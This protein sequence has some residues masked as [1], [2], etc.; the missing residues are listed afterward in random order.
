MK[1]TAYTLQPETQKHIGK[2]PA[3]CVDGAAMEFGRMQN[4]PL[5]IGLDGML[6]YAKAHEHAFGSTLAE[7]CFLGPCFLQVVKGYRD[8]LNGNGAAA[9]E[10]ELITDS[11][12]NGALE[13]LFWDCLAAAGY[14][15]E[16]ADL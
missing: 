15:E 7:D 6:R 1:P 4:E 16:T 3:G 14:T 8:L 10:I 5:L 13:G 2:I 12:S 9:N 11:K